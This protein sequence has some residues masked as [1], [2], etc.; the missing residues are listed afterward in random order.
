M[1]FCWALYIRHI[2]HLPIF[3][4]A[5]ACHEYL[6]SGPHGV[7]DSHLTASSSWNSGLPQDNNGPD[8][9]RL[10]TQA[11]D[12]G[13]GTFYRGAWTAGQNDQNQYIQVSARI[14]GFGQTTF[15]KIGNDGTL[16]K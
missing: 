12:Y 4:G 15:Y 11:Y 5:Q 9:S 13:N 7:P 2:A 10:F 8:R 3:P 16:S 14:E 1:T 6:V